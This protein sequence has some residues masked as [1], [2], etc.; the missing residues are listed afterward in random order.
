MRKEIKEVYT[1][2]L[3][4]L[5]NTRACSIRYLMQISQ[6]L[7]ATKSGR[8]RISRLYTYQ[9][10]WWTRAV[11]YPLWS[12]RMVSNR[13]SRQSQR[14]VQAERRWEWA[15]PHIVPSNEYS[16]P[17]PNSEIR[18]ESRMSCPTLK[19]CIWKM[20][21]ETFIRI[22]DSNE[23]T[24]PH[25][26]RSFSTDSSLATGYNYS[27][28]TRSNGPRKVLRLYTNAVQTYMSSA[29]AARYPGK[30]QRS[31]SCWSRNDVNY[32]RLCLVRLAFTK[33]ICGTIIR[34]AASTYN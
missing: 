11:N 2:S 17:P 24:T 31:K 4:T 26:S 7:Q 30:W 33:R 8:A 5:V 18:E 20:A 13:R 15:R 14:R 19:H 25:G 29:V 10:L 3:S 16:F 22:D 12:T 34:N 9:S 27:F 1:A 6:S 21:K 28:S 23:W 32:K